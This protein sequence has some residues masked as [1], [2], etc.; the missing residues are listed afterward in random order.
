MCRHRERRGQ[1]QHSPE[2]DSSPRGA[3][4]KHWRIRAPGRPE[5]FT[6]FLQLIHKLQI[7]QGAPGA[8][9]W[10]RAG[11]VLAPAW[12]TGWKEAPGGATAAM[13]RDTVV[14]WGRT[15]GRG[16]SWGQKW[17][18]A[19]EAP[20]QSRPAQGPRDAGGP[21]ASAGG[22]SPLPSPP[23]LPSPAKSP[24]ES[25]SHTG[26]GSWGESWGPPKGAET[27]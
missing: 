23:L 3:K 18:S 26:P 25:A 19:R 20:G 10:L 7:P 8:P 14:K 16:G 15:K 13:W 27:R 4:Y 11:S 22:A 1:A 6:P 9:C 5:L 2:A 24:G 12:R 21:Q 17:G